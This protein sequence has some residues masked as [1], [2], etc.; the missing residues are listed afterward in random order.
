MGDLQSLFDI[1]HFRNRKTSGPNIQRGLGDIVLQLK[2]ADADGT[3]GEG[4]R[5]GMSENAQEAHTNIK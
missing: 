3:L 1:A 5:F 4:K 2:P